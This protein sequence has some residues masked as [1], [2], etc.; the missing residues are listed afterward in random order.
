MS[1]IARIGGVER[2]EVRSTLGDCLLDTFARCDSA[3]SIRSVDTISGVFRLNDLG[4]V[5]GVSFCLG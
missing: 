4:S 3:K 1:L 5:A 2:V